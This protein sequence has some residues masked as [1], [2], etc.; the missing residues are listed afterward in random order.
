MH[1]YTYNIA[2]YRKDTAHLS[3]LEHGIYRQ[4]ID[5]YYLDEK[6]IPR[7][8]QMVMRRLRLGSESESQALKNVLNDFFFL[9]EDG[10]HQSRCDAELKAYHRKVKNNQVNGKLGGRPKKTTMVSSGNPDGTQQ[11]P[12]RNPNQTLTNNQEP[13][14]NKPPIVPQGGRF[15]EFWSAWPT[16]TRKVA[17][18][19]CQTKWAK[20][21]LDGVADRILAHVRVMKQTDSW[22]TGFEPAPLTYLNQK[23]WEDD[24]PAQSSGKPEWMRGML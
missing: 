4:L 14:T 13:I 21:K 20:Q 17:K 22:K 23:R 11:E 18:S 12:N 1:Y 8:T 9:E 3:A 19:A 10:Y 6:P 16:S 7:E 5:W 2:D 24:L 15:D